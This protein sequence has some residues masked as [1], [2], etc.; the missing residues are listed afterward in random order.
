MIGNYTHTLAEVISVM[1]VV[2][3]CPCCVGS[4]LAAA[5]RRFCVFLRAA[6]NYIHDSKRFQ[7]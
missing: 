1:C 6:F 5:L 4:A 2:C 3:M 7:T